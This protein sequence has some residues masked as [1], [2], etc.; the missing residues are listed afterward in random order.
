MK[1]IKNTVGALHSHNSQHDQA[2]LLYE[3]CVCV[4]EGG[5][6]RKWWAFSFWLPPPAY[7]H[8]TNKG[9]MG[10]LKRRVDRPQIKHWCFAWQLHSAL[11]LL[12]IYHL[13]CH[14]PSLSFPY[15]LLLL[16]TP[17]LFCSI[18]TLSP[19]TG[20][21]WHLSTRKKMC[22]TVLVVS[23]ESHFPSSP[24]SG[25][26][27]RKDDNE[28]TKNQEKVVPLLSLKWNFF[29]HSLALWKWHTEAA[30]VPPC[31]FLSLSHTVCRWRGENLLFILWWNYAP[32]L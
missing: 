19:S 13:E 6:K 24:S 28:E 31:L 16:S 9:V 32:C 23:T 12:P 15:S 4:Y 25:R 5:K 17:L 27:L 18:P 26:S 3:V 22:D 7:T 20:T 11:S 1:L 30:S 2:E 14:P 29:S 21:R 8:F 10:V